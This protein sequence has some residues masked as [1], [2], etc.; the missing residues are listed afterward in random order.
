MAGNGTWLSEPMRIFRAAYGESPTQA[1]I[2]R[3]ARTFKELEAEQPRPE[4]HARFARYCAD[5]PLK[6]WS[7]ERFAVTFAN[8]KV[9]R[10]KDNYLRPDEVA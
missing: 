10:V 3:M 5:T 1:A 6:F 4:I 2:K 8:W 9:P 7:P